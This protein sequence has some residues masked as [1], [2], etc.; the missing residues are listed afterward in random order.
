MVNPDTVQLLLIVEP[1]S[2]FFQPGSDAL[3]IAHELAVQKP[4]PVKLL[5]GIVRT[6]FPPDSLE[7]IYSL[8]G[9][10]EIL[11]AG[12][13]RLDYHHPVVQV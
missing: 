2:Y 1:F 12:V 9:L 8:F 4:K 5:E 10:S 6:G 7:A 3:E 11:F 13:D